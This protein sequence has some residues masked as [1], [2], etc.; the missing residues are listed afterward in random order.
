MLNEI[1]MMYFVLMEDD[2]LIFGMR[3]VI[4][5]LEAGKDIEKILIQ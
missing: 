1:N 2:N 5:A 3:A 4:E